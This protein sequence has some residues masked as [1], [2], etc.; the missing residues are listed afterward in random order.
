MGN[1]KYLWLDFKLE[2]KPNYPQGWGGKP[3]IPRARDSRVAERDIVKV[4]DRKL[5]FFV[6]RLFRG[7]KGPPMTA[8]ELISTWTEEER[9]TY[10]DLIAECLE[11]EKFLDGLRGKISACQGELQHTLDQLLSAL[12]HL[13][14]AVSQT[15][16]QFQGL[17]LR[18]S[19]PKGNA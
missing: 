19:K 2:G 18:L 1:F 17:Y 7:K 13:A 10:A 12:S 5:G 6:F 4:T 16:D 9:I 3:R 8:L 15:G 14:E 11:R